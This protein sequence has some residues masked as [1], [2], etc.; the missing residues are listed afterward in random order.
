MKINNPDI[1][2]D[3]DK[4]IYLADPSNHKRVIKTQMSIF[5]YKYV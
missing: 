3:D 2:L 4:T 5:A 1:L